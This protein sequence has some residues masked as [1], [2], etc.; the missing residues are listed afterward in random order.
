[1]P[2][3]TL[4]R[5]ADVMHVG[6][7][8]MK[9]RLCAVGSLM[10][11]CMF[12]SGPKANAQ[13][14]RPP[15]VTPAGDVNRGMMID[16]LEWRQ[17]YDL[18]PFE[19]SSPTGPL[20]ISPESLVPPLS[21][22]PP[23]SASEP[24]HVPFI[25][26]MGASASGSIPAWQR[27]PQ[28][29]PFATDHLG[30]L[31][32]P[33]VSVPAYGPLTISPDTMSTPPPDSVARP[34]LAPTPPKCTPPPCHLGASGGAR[35]A[36]E[37]RNL[38]GGKLG[39]TLLGFSGDD[40]CVL[41][42]SLP[43]LERMDRNN[44]TRAMPRLPSADSNRDA[45]LSICHVS[46]AFFSSWRYTEEGVGG[47]RAGIIAVRGHAP[48]GN[49]G[50]CHVPRAARSLADRDFTGSRPRAVDG[51][52]RY[53]HQHGPWSVHFRRMGLDDPPPPWLRRG[54]ATAFWRDRQ[55]PHGPG[56]ALLRR[57]G[58]STFAGRWPGRGCRASA[59]PTTSWSARRS[60]TFWIAASATSLSVTCRAGRTA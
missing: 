47:G 23:L 48:S 10:P 2:G 15:V 22:E 57:H 28:A 21:L 44:P 56:R 58:S 12:L 17:K 14:A 26:S 24:T 51:V 18:F 40:G 7:I 33:S 5:G 6:R 52:A 27:A 34:Q 38:A 29:S 20:V 4:A 25:N 39:Q 16:A 50:S 32:L 55:P 46:V 54:R 30:D 9:L 60:N 53:M 3:E 1:M 35:I 42:E 13:D 37:A 8:A 31:V 19:Q 49:L 45:L 11:V 43:R 59:W 41:H 36:T